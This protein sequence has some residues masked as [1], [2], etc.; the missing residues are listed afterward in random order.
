MEPAARP[1]NAIHQCICGLQRP[2]AT[3]SPTE[4]IHGDDTE[5]LSDLA[6]IWRRRYRVG[7]P[8]SA[9]GCCSPCRRLSGPACRRGDGG[10]RPRSVGKA[11]CQEIAAVNFLRHAGVDEFHVPGV[12]QVIA[13]QGHLDVLVDLPAQPRIQ[14]GVAGGAFTGQLGNRVD[15]A[16][17]VSAFVLR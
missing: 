2:C 3:P 10:T 12:Q 15:G 6:G 4:H 8:D 13:V 14:F 5:A 1:L 16:V 7:A 11:R 9:P 17:L